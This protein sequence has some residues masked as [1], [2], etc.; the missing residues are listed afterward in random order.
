MVVYKIVVG[1]FTY[2]GTTSRGLSRR[3]QEHNYRLGDPEAHRKFC[4]TKFY[5]KLREL[6][7]CRINK[8]NCIKICDG[9]RHEEQIEIE[10]IPMEYSL[11]SVRSIA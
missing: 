9:G 7:V 2:I 3:I 1:D 10:K 11:N 6:G 4:R 5:N 8:D